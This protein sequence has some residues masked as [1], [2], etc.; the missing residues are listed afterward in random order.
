MRSSEDTR[1]FAL[2][3]TRNVTMGRERVGMYTMDATHSLNDLCVRN[4]IHVVRNYAQ[5]RRVRQLL[6]AC[7]IPGTLR[8]CTFLYTGGVQSVHTVCSYLKSASNYHKGPLG[9]QVWLVSNCRNELTRWLFH[10]NCLQD[11]LGQFGIGVVAR[12]GAMA[13]LLFTIL[14]AEEVKLWKCSYRVYLNP[15]DGH[16]Y[17]LK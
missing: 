15:L 12:L 10:Y 8:K 11:R 1:D 17:L 14:L 7:V 2:W 13:T 5:C 3:C 16:G 9:A 6:H 4:N